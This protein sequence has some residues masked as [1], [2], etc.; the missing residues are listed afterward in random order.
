MPDVVII[1]EQ[2]PRVPAVPALL[3]QL[4]YKPLVVLPLAQRLAAQRDTEARVQALQGAHP[5]LHSRISALQL[6]RSG[7]ACHW[8]YQDL[9][10]CTK[11]TLH[12]TIAG[13]VRSSAGQCTHGTVFAQAEPN[14]TKAAFI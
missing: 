10:M 13:T 11:Q 4:A 6:M 1:G 9:T 7:T 2:Q 8:M 3:L 12:A 14:I 5:A